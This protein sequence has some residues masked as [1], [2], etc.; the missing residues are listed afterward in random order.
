MKHRVTKV[1]PNDNVLVALANLEEGE[2]VTYNGSEFVLASRVPAKH[3]FVTT[4]MQPGDPVTMYGVLVGKA[5][6]P[7]PKGGVITTFNLKH[8]ANSFEVGERKL[9]WNKPDVSK[10]RNRTFLGYNRADG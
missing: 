4:D 7:I 9:Q 10:F 3:K 8:A 5:E 1:H 2:R 6:K